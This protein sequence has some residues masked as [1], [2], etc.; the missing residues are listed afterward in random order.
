M[1]L[2]YSELWSHFT[3]RNQSWH[4]HKALKLCSNADMILAWKW[5][6][7]D[8]EVYCFY[9]DAFYG[10][11][12]DSFRISRVASQDRDSR[13]QTK[14][15]SCRSIRSNP[16]RTFHPRRSKCNNPEADRKWTYSYPQQRISTDYLRRKFE[17]FERLFRFKLGKRNNLG[18]RP[19]VAE[20]AP[21]GQYNTEN[22]LANSL[23]MV[24][25]FP[26]SLTP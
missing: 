5:F 16:Q 21:E 1:Y 20:I 12:R 10:V 14:A 8:G 6:R 9:F 2:A 4:A 25:L 23:I 13:V 11:L 15:V 7:V 17:T 3:L 18:L 24:S 26:T 19:V 22:S